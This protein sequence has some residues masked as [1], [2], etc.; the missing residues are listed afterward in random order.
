VYHRQHCIVAG[1]AVDAAANGVLDED[2]DC[3]G[4]CVDPAALQAL[5][6]VLDVDAVLHEMRLHA[7]DDEH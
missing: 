4:A 7:V 3:A 6:G 2:A 5:Q 1:G